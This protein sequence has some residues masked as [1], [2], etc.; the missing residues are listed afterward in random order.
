MAK[1]EE[2]SQDDKLTAMEELFAKRLKEIEDL[3][4]ELENR[5][6]VLYT[7]TQ[8]YNPLHDKIV[9]IKLA[10]KG[11]TDVIKD[12]SEATLL[13]GAKRSYGAQLDNRGRVI[14]PLNDEEKK[15]FEK[16][17]NIDLNPD[18]PI[19][20]NFWA[21]KA[22]KLSIFKTNRDIESATVKLHL[23]KPYD[24]IL[25]KVALAHDKIAN[26]IDELQKNPLFEMVIVDEQEVFIRELEQVEKEDAVSKH[27]MDNKN[28]RKILMD[29][30]RLYGIGGINRIVTF[31]TPI[32]Q[33]YTTARKITKLPNGIDK[34]YTIIQLTPAVAEIKVL[35]ED[36]LS[37]GIIEVNGNQYSMK[38]G[39]VIGFSKEAVEIYLN[40]RENQA[41]K[42]QI[43]EA[44]KNYLITKI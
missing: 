39:Q 2:L 37:A 5:A 9:T 10:Q 44:V 13:T 40:A 6:K 8:E 4:R 23:L 31:D 29:L 22:S 38:G 25:Y 20:R 18:L 21:T 19:D 41:V 26:S 36:A 17:L 3:K 1:K 14:C 35:I 12:S 16:L 34:L 24:F 43:K 27:L 7:Q 33:L 32:E 28:N 30:L 15:F 42:L 11:I